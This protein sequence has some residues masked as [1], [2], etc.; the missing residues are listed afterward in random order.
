[1]KLTDRISAE[2]ADKAIKYCEETDD[3]DG[4]ERAKKIKQAYLT[5][6]E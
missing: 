5:L 4:L 2:K 3:K 1:L 6:Q